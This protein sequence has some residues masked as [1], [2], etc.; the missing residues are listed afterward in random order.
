MRTEG[1]DLED[2]GQP[3]LDLRFADDIVVFATSSQQVAYLL[4]ELV[5]AL[6]DVGLI[7]N[8]DKTKLPTTQAQPPTTITSPGGFSVAVVDRHGCDKWFG[9][10]LRGKQQGKSQT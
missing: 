2:G 5:V 8:Q 1:I 6:A 10:I 3:L 9:C 4:D 7:L